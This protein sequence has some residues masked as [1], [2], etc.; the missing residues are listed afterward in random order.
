MIILSISVFRKITKGRKK[1]YSNLKLEIGNW[2]LETGNL[3][4]E[5]DIPHSLLTIH[6]NVSS[7]FSR[8]SNLKK[9][10]IVS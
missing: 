4:F 1:S 3:K 8:I 7:L 9:E 10:S 5:I 6:Q 2:K